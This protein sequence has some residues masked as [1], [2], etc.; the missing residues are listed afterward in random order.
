MGV[1][2]GFTAAGFEGVRDAFDN[3]FDKGLE[4]GACFSAYYRGEKV[5]DLWGGIADE[6]TGRPWT[7][8]TLE[9]F[10]ST[11][12]G[13]TAI[14]AHKLA[15]EGKLDLDAPVAKYWPEFAQA[16][17]ENIPVSYLLSHRAGLAW[18]DGTMTPDEAFAWE[19]VIAVLE[20]QTPH[21]EPGTEHGYH[22]TTYGW[23]VGEVIRRVTGK[24]VG[25]YFR[26]AI[27][28]PLDL[29][30]WIGLPES[31]ES[32]VARLVGGIA[33]DGSA[34]DEETRKLMDQFMGP[35]TEAGRALFAPGGALGGRDVYNTRACHAAEIPAAGGIGDARSLARLYAACIGEVDGI[36]V[37]TPEQ[38]KIASTQQTEGP[39]RVLMGLDL[40]FGLGFIVP[41]SLISLGGPNS[42]GHFGAGGSVGWADPDAE[43]AFGYVMN[44]ME[45]GLAGDTRSTDLVAACYAA[46]S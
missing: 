2:Q 17:K 45:M 12:K 9:V 32:R 23:L 22:A 41:S 7:E 6:T 46:T 31:E 4:V 26:D 3:N 18:V 16:G 14:C 27:G 34:M 39:N 8:D 5:V 20:A 19:P 25:R 35:D 1:G 29:D 36:R 30:I 33:P 15:Q 21:W 28:D 11:T 42:F 13:V 40:Q 38:V 43:F 24:S 10:F 37:L 44:R